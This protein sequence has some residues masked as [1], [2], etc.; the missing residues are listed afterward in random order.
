MTC[1][2]ENVGICI[3]FYNKA[4]E[5]DSDKDYTY[6]YFYEKVNGCETIKWTM[7]A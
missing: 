1:V 7:Q 3:E 6:D 4:M 2:S 5:E